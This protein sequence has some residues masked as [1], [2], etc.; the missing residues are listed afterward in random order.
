MRLSAWLCLSAAVMVAAAQDRTPPAVEVSLELRRDGRWEAADNERV[1]NAGDQIR[2]RFRTFFAGYLHVLNRTSGGESAWLYPRPE[3][4]QSGRV[5]PGPVYL[6]PGARGSFVVGGT[7]GFDVTFW[8]IGDTPMATSAMPAF[9]SQPNTLLPRCREQV[10][11][12]RGLCV[13][14]RAGPRPAE[15]L[16]ARELTFRSEGGPTRI[17]AQDSRPGVMVYEFRIAHR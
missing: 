9:G 17:S 16:T 2:F 1:F 10:L 6:I 15:G 14:G 4:E 8:V 12:A 3:A 5:E 13:D 11:K 7:P